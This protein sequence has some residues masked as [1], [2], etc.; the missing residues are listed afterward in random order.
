M[1]NE[2]LIKRLSVD[3]WQKTL[4]S[5]DSENI[6]PFLDQMEMIKTED[7]IVFNFLNYQGTY[8]ESFLLSI[9]PFWKNFTIDQ[10]KSIFERLKGNALAEYYMKVCA[11]RL[12]GIDPDF[13]STRNLV[14]NAITFPDNQHHKASAFLPEAVGNLREIYEKSLREKY[15]ISFHDLT[16]VNKLLTQ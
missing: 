14:I 12:L 16:E 6:R 3:F 1:D 2:E 10:W 4:F 11:G 13:Q 5:P 8:L 9:F 15:S 7:L